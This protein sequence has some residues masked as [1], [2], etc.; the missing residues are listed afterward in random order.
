MIA[1]IQARMSSKRLPGK[2]LKK[3]NGKPMLMRIVENIKKSKNIKKIYIATSGSPKD[4]KIVNFCKRNRFNFFKGELN[5][6]SLRFKTFL[7]K[8]ESGCKEFVRINGDSPFIDSALVDKFVK[9]FKKKKPN[10]LT[11]TFPRTFPKGQSIEIIN[12]KFFI[13]NLKYFKHPDDKEHVTHFFYRKKYKGILNL[14]RTRN[15]SKV[16]MCV[17]TKKDLKIA[18]S[19][20]KN[21]ID[22]QKQKVCWKSLINH[23]NEKK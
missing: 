15:Y 8:K 4:N 2:V 23:F 18:R 20:Y 14:K 3:I 12:S 16:N 19:V 22:K 13:T 10:I 11:N 9:I 5:N 17:D 21:F 7:E 6:V 1:I